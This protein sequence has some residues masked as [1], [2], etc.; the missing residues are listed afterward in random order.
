MLKLDHIGYEADG[1]AGTS[2]RH[3]DRE[4]AAIRTLHVLVVEDDPADLA[5]IERALRRMTTFDVHITATGTV[6]AARRALKLSSFDLAL[7]DQTLDDAAGT[8]LLPAAG[9]RVLG[10]PA[11]LVT[12]LLTADLHHE[13]LQRGFSACLEKDELTPRILEAIIGQ[14]ITLHAL[15]EQIARLEATAPVTKAVPGAQFPDVCDAEA[16]LLDAVAGLQ[17]RPDIEIQQAIALSLR[18]GSAPLLVSAAEGDLLKEIQSRLLAWI[19]NGGSR[20]PVNLRVEHDDSEAR[21]VVVDGPAQPPLLAW[22]DADAGTDDA[23][24][25]ATLARRPLV[26]H[27]RR[28]S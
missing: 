17:T 13:A 3:G 5:L 21:I 12:G 28:L 26:K 27:L 18:L 15:H 22:R 8:T 1:S 6:E 20:G 16:M 11:I 2:Y 14:A 19:F 10:C 25:L 9:A 4:V 24:V 7:V 23:I